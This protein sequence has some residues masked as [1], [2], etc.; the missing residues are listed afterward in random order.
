MREPKLKPRFVAELRERR[1][2]WSASLHLVNG[3]AAVGGGTRG[4]IIGWGAGAA[5]A[6]RDYLQSIDYAKLP[7]GGYAVTLT[8]RKLMSPADWRQLRRRLCWW[9]TKRGAS[10]H[11]V[12]EWQ[13]RGVPHLHLAVWGV[14]GADVV[15]WW[16]AH[17]G[18]WRSA[19]QAQHHRRIRTPAIWAQYCAKH[20]SRGLAHYQRNRASLVGAWL[21]ESAGRMW[22]HMGAKLKA[23]YVA[24]RV[25]SYCGGE[26]DY[27]LVAKRMLRMVGGGDN[28]FFRGCGAWG[29]FGVAMDGFLLRVAG[30]TDPP[31]T[32]DS[33]ERQAILRLEAVGVSAG[34]LG[35]AVAFGAG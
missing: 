31:Q 21:R 25:W 8:T 30:S 15:D 29:S 4:A 6:N 33:I 7:A 2:G 28:Q 26:A 27:A 23:A 22:G 16:L 14:S 18:S 12:V 3:Q 17:T 35:K 10:A 9:L 13:R 5:R 1:L 11:W 19:R 24:P 20:G 34:V 32:G